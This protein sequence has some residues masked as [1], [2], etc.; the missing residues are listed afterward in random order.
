[1]QQNDLVLMVTMLL[2]EVIHS[3]H[4]LHSVN[5]LDCRRG[6]TIQTKDV[7][8]VFICVYCYSKPILYWWCP[9]QT[10]SKRLTGQCNYNVHTWNYLSPR[11]CFVTKDVLKQFFIS[12]S[13]NMYQTDKYIYAPMLLGAK[14]VQT[15]LKWNLM[16]QIIKQC[17]PFIIF[18]YA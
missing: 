10:V 14:L 4:R 18:K 13:L 5:D 15:F 11:V 1:M 7:S 2:T 9:E 17:R 16:S 12:V 8:A 3:W 6:Q